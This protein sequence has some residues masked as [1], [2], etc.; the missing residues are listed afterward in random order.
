MPA[1]R[2]NCGPSTRRGARSRQCWAVDLHLG[3]W[4]QAVVPAGCWQMA[5]S[6]GDRTLPGCT[7]A[8]GFDFSQFELPNPAGSP[9][10]P[11]RLGYAA[12]LSADAALRPNGIDFA[13]STAPPVISTQAA[14]MFSVGAAKPARIRI[15]VESNGAA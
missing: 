11:S 8:P 9:A 7:V 12:V 6:L 1:R 15:S 4:P 14:R 13:A 10:T 2:S 5:R 3:E